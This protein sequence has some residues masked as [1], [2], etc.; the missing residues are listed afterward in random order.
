MSNNVFDKQKVQSLKGIDHSKKG[1]FDAPIH[2]L[3]VFIN[4]QPNFF[5][6]SSC[7]GRL[8]IFREGENKKKGCKWLLS[9]HDPVPTEN[10]VWKSSNQCFGRGWW[11]DWC[12]L[13]IW[14]LYF[15]CP[16]SHLGTCTNIFESCF[17]M[18]LQKFWSG[19]REK[20]ENHAGRSFNS[21]FR[22]STS[23]WWNY[24][25][26]KR[27]SWET[28]CTSERQTRGEFR[29]DWQILQCFE[30]CAQ[31][32]YV[33]TYTYESPSYLSTSNKDITFSITHGCQNACLESR[34]SSFFIWWKWFQLFG[35]FR[36]L[37]YWHYISQY[38]LVVLS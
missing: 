37:F 13:Q 4:S 19:H 14:I 1:S 24:T 5:T 22:G 30:R 3:I 33:T 21:W 36:I 8:H 18:W 10:V 26:A 38:R 15:T 17:G 12:H 2:D 23:I 20:E 32:R 29:Q 16:M 27:I 7:S 34:L 9:S 31:S 11:F 35:S 28:G 25:S 6:T